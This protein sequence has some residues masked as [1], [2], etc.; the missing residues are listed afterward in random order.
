MNAQNDFIDLSDVSLVAFLHAIRIRPLH[1]QILDG[2][3]HWTYSN[4]LELQEAKRKFYNGEAQVDA[5]DMADHL[6]R[7]KLLVRDLQKEAR[8]KGGKSE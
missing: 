5:Q 7:T 8:Q 3:V 2:H 4:S 6:R 1:H